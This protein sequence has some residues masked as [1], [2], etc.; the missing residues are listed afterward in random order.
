MTSILGAIHKRRRPIFL[1]LWPPP[2]PF[3][4]TSFMDGPLTEL[5]LCSTY[6]VHTTSKVQTQPQKHKL[7]NYFV[8]LAKSDFRTFFLR[9]LPRAP[10]WRH[11][12][13]QSSRS[14]VLQEFLIILIGETRW[15]WNSFESIRLRLVLKSFLNWIFIKILFSKNQYMYKSSK[16]SNSF[17]VLW[18]KKC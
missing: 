5:L 16:Y 6:E 14:H 4:E 7:D 1:I 12:S 11:C 13:G 18:S 3:K 10:W 8:K 17:L 9:I 2:A 15:V